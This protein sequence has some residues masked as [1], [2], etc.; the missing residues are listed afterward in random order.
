MTESTG[1]THPAA[2]DETDEELAKKV[3]GQT[4]PDLDAEDV[5]EREAGGTDSDRAAADEGA[6][7]VR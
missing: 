1:H 7:E 3:A 2:E 5:F 4:A 6:D